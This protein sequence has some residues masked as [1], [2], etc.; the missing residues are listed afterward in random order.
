[1]SRPFHFKQFSIRQDHAAMKVGTDAVLLGAWVSHSKAKNILDIG[2]GTGLLTLMMAQRFE[3]SFITGIEIDPDA[4][5]DAKYNIDNSEWGDRI[6]LIN[7]S[8]SNFTLDSKVDLI[9][10]NP[11]FFP[12]DTLAPDQKRALARSGSGYSFIDWLRISSSLVEVNGKIAFILPIDYW[13]N[14]EKDVVELGFSIYRRCN[15]KPTPQKDVHRVMIELQQEECTSTIIEELT[16][17]N[18]KRHD[19]TSDYIALTHSFYLKM[20]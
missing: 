19:Y 17:E 13:Q 10:T 8:I 9:I 7:E 11:P 14:I 5:L 1:M 3:N 15:V 16:I 6:Q 2:C 18:N 4:M 20:L 12:Y